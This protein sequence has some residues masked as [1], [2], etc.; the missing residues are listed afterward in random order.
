MIDP[1]TLARLL[2]DLGMKYTRS[3]EGDRFLLPF[4]SDVG[5]V[6]IQ[7]GTD[8]EGA[9]VLLR[10]PVQAALP[11]SGD[12]QRGFF[13]RLLEI[14][15]GFALGKTLLS[16]DAV[17]VGVEIN[18]SA[19]SSESLQL[20]IAAVLSAVGAVTRALQTKPA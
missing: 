7:L 10:A 8:D 18:E 15:D 9:W 17:G 2:T 20:G 3:T 11:E 14:N 6:F 13:R 12:E 4:Q 19:L 1:N 16:G 5:Q